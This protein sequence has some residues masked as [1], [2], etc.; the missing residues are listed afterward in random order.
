MIIP[1]GAHQYTKVEDVE[2]T[3]DVIVISEEDVDNANT[4]E[5]EEL[6]GIQLF[7]EK[8][9]HDGGKLVLYTSGTTGR[10]NGVIVSYDQFILLILQ[11]M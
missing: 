3:N 10:S 9:N 8:Y 6:K 1:Y 2:F 7:L 5:K 11:S 4:I